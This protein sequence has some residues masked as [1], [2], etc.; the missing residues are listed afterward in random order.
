[1]LISG[2]EERRDISFKYLIANRRIEKSQTI[3]LCF[4]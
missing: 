1:M 4:L 2:F 3:R